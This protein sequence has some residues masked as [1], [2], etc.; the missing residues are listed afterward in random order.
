MSF[1]KFLL[2][3]NEWFLVKMIFRFFLNFFYILFR[4]NILAFWIFVVKRCKYFLFSFL[5][6]NRGFNVFKYLLKLYEWL[7]LWIGTLYLFLYHPFNFL[8]TIFF[9]SDVEFQTRLFE[10]RPFNF[11]GAELFEFGR[12]CDCKMWRAICGVLIIVEL[13]N[14]ALIFDAFTTL[15]INNHLNLTLLNRIPI[16]LWFRQMLTAIKITNIR[17]HRVAYQGALIRVSLF[18]NYL[19]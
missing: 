19:D 10:W 16:I 12:T 6:S 5:S 14:I 1:F 11:I 13:K 15:G 8:K 3:E 4:N 2:R 18:R 7:A 9:I 17:N